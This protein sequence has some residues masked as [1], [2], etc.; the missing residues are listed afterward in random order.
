VSCRSYK[1]VALSKGMK[2]ISSSP[3]Y[4]AFIFSS[5][6]IK[7]IYRQEMIITACNNLKYEVA[8][9]NVVMAKLITHIKIPNHPKVVYFDVNVRPKNNRT[10][11][12]II[13]NSGGI[14]KGFM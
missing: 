14:V 8:S 12:N 10:E 5:L 2:R 3:F 1:K 9:D 4:T 11:A 7:I 6:K 13:A